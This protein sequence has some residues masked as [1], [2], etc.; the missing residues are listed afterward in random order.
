MVVRYCTAD[1][2]KRH[3]HANAFNLVFVD[4]F[5]TCR[6]MELLLPATNRDLISSCTY[7]L[8][9]FSV[10]QDD[11]SVTR[12][13]I[14]AGIGADSMGAMEAI[15]PT[16]KN[17]WGRCPQA[18]PTG[19]LLCQFLE[20]VKLVITAKMYSKNYGYEY[21]IMQLID[22]RCDDFSLKMHQKRL[23]VSARTCWGSLERSPRPLAEF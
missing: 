8:Y 10:G 16:A 19:I 9:D 3:E 22:K 11:V 17:L 15:A 5:I 21:V 12:W 2:L 23:A 18:A 13:L 14:D 1:A 20:T 6:C 4:V 7:G